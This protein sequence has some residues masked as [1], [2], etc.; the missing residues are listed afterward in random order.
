MNY[1]DLFCNILPAWLSGFAAVVAIIVSCKSDRKSNKLQERIANENIELQKD[2][3]CRDANMQLYELRL[4]VYTSFMRALDVEQRVKEAKQ[5]L[6]ITHMQAT[7][8]LLNELT[9]CKLKIEKNVNIASFCFAHDSEIWQ[10]IND[11]K[12]PFF[13]FCDSILDNMQNSKKIAL[14]TVEKMITEKP[15]NAQQILSDM[16]NCNTDSLFYH[17]HQQAISG[18][19]HEADRAFEK[20]KDLVSYEK[21]GKLFEKYLLPEAITVE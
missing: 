2:I 5:K 14:L 21:F 4:W 9:E 8:D 20:Y 18:L 16:I 15:E 6:P 13:I 17:T 1:I 19:A 3:Q 10:A 12:E 11:A 7:T